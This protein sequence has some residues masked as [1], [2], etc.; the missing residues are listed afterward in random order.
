MKLDATGIYRLYCPL[1]DRSRILSKKGQGVGVIPRQEALANLAEIELS[2]VYRIET[3][4]INCKL[5]TM[6]KIVKALEVS[7]KELF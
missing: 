4:R 2:Q 1:V 3:G 7:P 5:L 6:L